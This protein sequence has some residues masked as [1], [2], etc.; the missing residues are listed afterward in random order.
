M[1]DLFKALS[2]PTRRAIIKLLRKHDM[3]AGD[4]AAEFPL[5]KPTLSKHFNVL[6]ESGLIQGTRAGTTI[7]Y[8]LNLSV[9]EDALCGAMAAFNIQPP[10]SNKP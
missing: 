3:T 6:K 10:N 4:I 1:P 7:T 5:A 8:T 2:D 9:L